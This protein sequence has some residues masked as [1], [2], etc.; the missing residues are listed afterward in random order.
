MCI[1][2]LFNGADRLPYKDIAQQTDIPAAELKRSLQSLACVKGKQILRKEP[3]GKEVEEEDEFFF[4]EKFTSK[5]HKASCAVVLAVL[6]GVV[7]PA[8]HRRR[9]LP[10]FCMRR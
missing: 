2:L 6:L 4:N 1:L 3:Q 7:L 5:L 8:S 10:V 9:S